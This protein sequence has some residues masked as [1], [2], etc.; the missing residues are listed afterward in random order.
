M[1]NLQMT[2]NDFKDLV[3]NQEDCKLWIYSILGKRFNH[4]IN[5]GIQ[6]EWLVLEGEYIKVAY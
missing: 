2:N 1:N 5:N 4:I 6:A 3:N